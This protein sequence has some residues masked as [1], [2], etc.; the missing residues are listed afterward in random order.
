MVGKINLFFQRYGRKSRSRK[1]KTAGFTILE[2]LVAI[3]ISTAIVILLGELVVDLL[4]T[5][6]REYA[7]TE[8]EREMQMALDYMVNDLREAAYVY[9]NKEL[10]VGRG[11]N[12]SVPRLRDKI[13]NINGYEPILAFWKPEQI[14]YQE[15][16]SSTGINCG[17][18]P[19][20]VT[21]E[22]Q[23]CNN[24]QIR[25]RTLTLVVY[26]QT[27]NQAADNQKW[28][29]RSRI[30]R[31]QLR[32]FPNSAFNDG[33][34]TQAEQ[35]PKY[36]APLENSVTF[37]TW[38]GTLDGNGTF[39]DP[40][41]PIATFDNDTAPVLVDFVD[42][43]T[44]V[45]GTRRPEDN[46]LAP[47]DSR[48][49]CPVTHPPIPPRTGSTN[50]FNDPSFVACVSDST[51]TTSSSGSVGTPTNQDVILFLRGNPTGKAGIKIP[52][53]IAVRTQAVARGV[54]DKKPE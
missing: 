26:Y 15:T 41:L 21:Q 14:P 51:A 12:N 27:I 35:N 54:I 42:Y 43:P 31:F 13:P 19:N 52:P 2:L 47:S 20:P 45:P 53:L 6:R 11:T 8:T 25:R 1:G 49:Q 36:V 28:K 4:Q 40:G 3:L 50:N 16:S 5:D 48:D 9:N 37:V 7:R 44:G 39:I 38:P 34:V 24:Q 46:V 17:S 18:Q 32:R 23:F 30:V 33:S 22:W 29:G 10:N